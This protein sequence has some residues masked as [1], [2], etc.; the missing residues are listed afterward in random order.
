MNGIFHLVDEL[1]G[2]I[3]NSKTVPFSNGKIFVE[4]DRVLEIIDRLRAILPEE[5]EAAKQILANKESVMQSAYS[6][7]SDYLAASKERA[8]KMLDDNEITI[9]ALHRS[10]TMLEQARKAALEIR[11]DAELYADEIL[12]HMEMV[13]KRGLEAI[14][15]SKEQMNESYGDDDGY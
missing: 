7:A 9:S 2:L 8:A 1:E 4:S 6:E 3:K 13:L 12:T 10:E 11:R 15:A 5:L 14:A